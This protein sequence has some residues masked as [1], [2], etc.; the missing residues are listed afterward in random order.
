VVMA[1]Q[2][3]LRT[4]IAH[5][6]ALKSRVAIAS[7]LDPLP[8]AEV[9]NLIRYRLMVAGRRAELFTPD[10]YDRVFI[11]SQGIPRAICVICDNALLH[12]FLHQKDTIDWDIVD[13]AAQETVI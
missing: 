2:N 5:S 1:G 9:P 4:K 12:A 10:A 6:K 13:R 8:P 7:T 3:E 11:A